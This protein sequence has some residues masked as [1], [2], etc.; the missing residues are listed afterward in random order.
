MEGLINYM[1]ENGFSHVSYYD[2][3]SLIGRESIG[4]FAFKRDS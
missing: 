1:K 3:E 4:T 2:L